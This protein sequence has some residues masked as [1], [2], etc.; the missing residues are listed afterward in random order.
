MERSGLFELIQKKYNPQ[1]VLY[2]GCS[3]HI[4]PAFFFPH[5]V[6][7][8]QDPNAAA[9]FSHQEMLLEFVSRHR[10]YR[11]TPFIQFIAQDFLQPLPVAVNEFNLLLA[12]FAGGITHG[13]KSYLK[14]DGLLITNNH[15][16]DAIDAF[17]DTDFTPLAMVE[18]RQG[19]YQLSPFQQIDIASL[20]SQGS[21]SK[22]Y[23]RSTSRGIKYVET[24][25][26][27]V[28]KKTRGVSKAH[29]P[30]RRAPDGG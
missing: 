5:L 28:F 23:L 15:Q 19:S 18:Y 20:K 30:T 21:R 13:C 12:L 8:D 4:T 3:V 24:E 16:N 10:R 14:T 17:H 11:R 27:Y 26:Y 29:R 2:P 25:C 7:V 1:L 6:F 9:F 22:R